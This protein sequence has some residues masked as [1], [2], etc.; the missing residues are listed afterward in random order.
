LQNL[1]AYL[2]LHQGSPIPRGQLAYHFWPD[3]SDEHARTHLRNLLFHLRKTLPL[4][5]E[6]FESDHNAIYW[7][8]NGHFQIDVVEFEN[9]ASDAGSIE[10]L[11]KAID[12]YTGD[13]QESEKVL[14]PSLSQAEEIGDP[15][16]QTHC[17]T[18]LTILYRMR[19][20]VEMVGNFARRSRRSS[21]ETGMQDY[22]FAARAL[23][24]PKQQRLPD[25]LTKALEQAV[26]AWDKEEIETAAIHLEKALVSA[27]VLGYL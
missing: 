22:Q 24:S 4:S 12:L 5:V 15:T 17:L 27:E 3:T 13:L 21:Q 16:L 26:A 1:F 8:A 2:V 9:F 20:Q 6:F 18:Y 7:H 10:A 19:G 25:L 23:L 14:Q 11:R